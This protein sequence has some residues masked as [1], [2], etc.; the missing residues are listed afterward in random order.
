MISLPDRRF[1]AAVMRLFLARPAL[2]IR[3][4]A[5]GVDVLR[6]RRMAAGV[7]SS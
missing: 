6:R 4:G 1:R 2:I 7:V 5:V 3:F